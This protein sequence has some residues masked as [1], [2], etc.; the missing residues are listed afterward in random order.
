MPDVYE[1]QGPQA[2]IDREK[3]IAKM[4]D[5]IRKDTFRTLI[6]KLPEGKRHDSNT[7]PTYPIGSISGEWAED[8]E[9]LVASQKNLDLNSSDYAETRS[10]AGPDSFD[11]SK[12][13]IS[14]GDD[15]N[16]DGGVNL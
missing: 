2:K 15:D 11:E 6:E 4:L 3:L 9:R 10:P 5:L 16:Y 13:L 12:E 8:M 1:D 14:E 7:D